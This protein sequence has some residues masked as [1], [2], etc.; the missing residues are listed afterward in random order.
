MC[1]KHFH[2]ETALE[3]KVVVKSILFYIV[4]VLEKVTHFTGF[5]MDSPSLSIVFVPAL[6]ISPQKNFTAFQLNDLLNFS[7][8]FMLVVETLFLSALS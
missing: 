8:M 5:E 6:S 4:Y 7:S 1:L 2:R 3:T